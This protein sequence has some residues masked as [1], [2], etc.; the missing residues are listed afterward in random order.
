MNI[1]IRGIQKYF[2]TRRG[3][4]TA[5]DHIDLTIAAGEFL[6]II[7]P[8]GCGK[9]TLLRMLAGLDTPS[10]GEIFVNG[11]VIHGTG[12]DRVMIFQD[13]ALFPWLNVEANVEFGLRMK[14]LPASE[15]TVITTQLL[16]TVHLEKFRHA[17][18]HELSGGMKQRVAL[19]RALAV[20]P[21][22]LLLDEPF[23]ALDAITRDL[24]HTEL[25]E[26]WLK[27]SKTVIFI[28]H[29]VR[30]AVVLGDR[31]LVMSAHPGRI[32]AEHRIELP[33]PRHIE[34]AATMEIA[35]RIATDLKIMPGNY[36]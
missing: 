26:V 12:P 27:T 36:R 32:V 18:I 16:N 8:S 4:V 9:S 3:R 24:L 35:R 6:C 25:Q 23:G 14:G 2:S 13:A 22:L 31:V 21:L 15:R 28:T 19:A 11:Q 20:D 1:E 30:E 7:G 5:L 29:N 34:D 10:A 17:W 33:R